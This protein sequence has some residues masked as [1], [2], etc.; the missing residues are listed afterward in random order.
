MMLEAIEVQCPYC[1]EPIEVLVDC[2][3]ASHDFIEDCA[4]CCRPI[5][6]QAEVDAQG[7][8]IGLSARRDDD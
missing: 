5:E 3:E 7:Q 6:L 1:G 4:V 8:L 2:S